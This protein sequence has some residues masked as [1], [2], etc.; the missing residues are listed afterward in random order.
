LP[1]Q[2]FACVSPSSAAIIAAAE[3]RCGEEE[4]FSDNL[5]ARAPDFALSYVFLL[6]GTDMP[7]GAPVGRW[8]L[9]EQRAWLHLCARL[10]LDPRYQS[11]IDAADLVQETLL[12]AHG[13]LDRGEF[14]GQTDVEFEA[15]L[16]TILAN[17]VRDMVRKLRLPASLENSLEQDLEKSSIRLAGLLA[18]D[19]TS[20]SQKA[21]KREDLSRLAAAL[22]QLPD[23]QRQAVELKHLHA[24]PVADIAE[25]LGKTEEAVGGLLYRGLKKLRTLLE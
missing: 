1:E 21:S 18:A 19:T 9:N 11:K 23:D 24:L 3:R 16:R 13:A 22:E 15:W 25:H 2:L 7:A 6:K 5:L 8:L 10:L 20:P 17:T 12:K 14:R 4:T